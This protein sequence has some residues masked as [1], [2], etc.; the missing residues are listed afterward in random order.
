MKTITKRLLVTSV[1]V[2]GLFAVSAGSQTTASAA[3]I[4]TKY[5]KLT[6]AGSKRNVA[7][8]G[9]YALYT[10]PGTVKGA[11]LVASKAQMKKFGTYSTAN[12]KYYATYSKNQAYKGSTYYF[13]A[14]GYQVTNTG[15]VYYKVVTMNGKYRG[16][17][18][19]GKRVGTFAGGIKSAAT[20]TTGTSV[21][22]NWTGSVGIYAGGTLWN[23]V[24]YTQYGTKKLGHMSDLNST[25]IPHLAQFKIDQVATRTRE[26]D[27]YY[28]VVSTDS[29]RLSGWVKSSYIGQYAQVKSN[30]D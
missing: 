6:T 22:V 17:V 5:T 27:T 25:T 30:W 2:M 8:N 4:K 24:P 10:K 15:A 23:Y 19:G 16:Y 21:P 20:T 1:A 14:Y 28:H 29:N 9:K 26:Q 12:Q 3:T 11:K 13:R 18:Y 7:A